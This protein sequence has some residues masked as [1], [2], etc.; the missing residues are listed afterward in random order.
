[1][2]LGPYFTVSDSRL[3]F[4]SPPTTHKVKG[5]Y[6][7]PPLLS[8]SLSVMLPTVSRSVCLGMKHPFVAYNQIFVT[9][10]QLQ[11]C[12][13]GAL[14]LTR[15]WVSSLKL[16]LGLARAV[17]LGSESRGTHDH[18]LLSKIRDFPFPC[19]LRLAGLRWRYSNPPPHGTS[20]LLL[21]CDF[22][23]ITS[24]RPEYSPLKQFLCYS[25]LSGATGI[26]V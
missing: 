21:N 14:S 3:S 17:I 16:L 5:R 4:S 8:L 6:S 20:P 9:V 26:C 10:R 11:V 22:F 15:R 1:V 19:L 7:T 12:W 13:C 24:R 18:I 2:G 25:V 23:F